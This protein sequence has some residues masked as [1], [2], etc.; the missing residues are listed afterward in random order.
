MTTVPTTRSPGC[1]GARVTRGNCRG[2]RFD[3]AT[4]PM[5]TRRGFTSV[6]DFITRE[7]DRFLLGYHRDEQF[8]QPVYLEVLIEKNTLLNIAS[9]RRRS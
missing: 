3:N 2:R 8:D 4:P 9:P 5:T 7:M 1:A 6:S